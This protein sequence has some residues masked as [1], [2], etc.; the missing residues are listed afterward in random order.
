MWTDSGPQNWRCSFAW[1]SLSLTFSTA[2]CVTGQVYAYAALLSGSRGCGQQSGWTCLHDGNWYLSSCQTMRTEHR[3]SWR[4]FQ[5][6]GGNSASAV[7]LRR[8]GSDLP[9][10]Q[11]I[12]FEV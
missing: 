8:V 12:S 2:S 4:N 3:N 1:T 10:A 6:H 9:L 11:E 7:R 5:R